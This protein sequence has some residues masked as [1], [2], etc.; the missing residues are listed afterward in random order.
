M[1]YFYTIL[2]VSTVL[3]VSSCKLNLNMNSEVPPTY[4][5]ALQKASSGKV[6]RI[7]ISDHSITFENPLPHYYYFTC[8][9]ATNPTSDSIPRL[10]AAVQA[11]K[12]KGFSIAI[13]DKRKK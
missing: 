10:F 2:F 3:A 7:T 13:D 4:D 8:S 5:A 11:A 6:A 9:V 12:E 1:R